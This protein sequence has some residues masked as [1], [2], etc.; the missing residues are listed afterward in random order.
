MGPKKY[1]P[2]S[3]VG[4]GQLYQKSRILDLLGSHNIFFRTF[5][6]NVRITVH[7]DIYLFMWEFRFPQEILFVVQKYLNQGFSC[8][9]I[10]IRVFCAEILV[11]YRYALP[12]HA[13]LTIWIGHGCNV[14]SFSGSIDQ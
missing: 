6:P 14:Y 1:R 10:Q 4:Q 3:I 11:R 12:S 8:K 5:T 9:Y 2:R 13:R 7:L